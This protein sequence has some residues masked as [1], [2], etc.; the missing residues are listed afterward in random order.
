[1]APV[2]P[3]FPPGVYVCVSVPCLEAPH[4]WGAANPLNPVAVCLTSVLPEEPVQERTGKC[5][6]PE[7]KVKDA[8]AKK[9]AQETLSF[10]THSPLGGQNGLTPLPNN[11]QRILFPPCLLV[12]P[13][14]I[15]LCSI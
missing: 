1:M 6:P 3:V 2:A 9:S 12:F 7:R 8:Q 11:T 10:Q 14:S 5:S 15:C 13:G 4:I